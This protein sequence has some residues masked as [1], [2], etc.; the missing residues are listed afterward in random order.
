MA[1]FE[2]NSIYGMR[3]VYVIADRKNSL[4]NQ[5]GQKENPEKP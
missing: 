3:R 1:A 2:C 4:L 5:T